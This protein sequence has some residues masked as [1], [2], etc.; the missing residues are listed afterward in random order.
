M[1]NDTQPAVLSDAQRETIQRI[2]AILSENRRAFLI[3]SAC[4]VNCTPPPDAPVR[5]PFRR[6]GTKHPLP[7]AWPTG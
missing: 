3:K 1:P 7:D 5:W 6:F 4:R 2:E